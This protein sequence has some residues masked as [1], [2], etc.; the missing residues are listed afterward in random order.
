MYYHYLHIY[1]PPPHPLIIIIAIPILPETPFIIMKPIEIYQ[2]K[3]EVINSRKNPQ[4]IPIK[5]INSPFHPNKNPKKTQQLQKKN[6]HPPR[7][8]SS[9][10]QTS[11]YNAIIY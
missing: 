3:K 8:A 10:I 1:K 6:E 11:G 4:K 5:H 9:T 7:N 2:T